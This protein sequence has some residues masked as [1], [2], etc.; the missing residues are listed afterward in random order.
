M[1]VFVT[2]AAG[3]IGKAVVKELIAHGHSVTGLTRSE[4]SASTITA[5]GGTPL[6]GDLKDLDSLKRGAAA[7]DGVIHLAFIH[8]FSDFA[9]ACATDRAAITAMAETLTGTGKPFVHASGTMMCEKDKIATE[10]SRHTPD[11]PFDER[12]K[13]ANLIYDL[14]EKGVRGSVLRFA[15]TV[16]ADGTGGLTGFLIDV[17]KGKGG[18]VVYV[19]DGQARWPACY[20]DDAA[21]LARLALEKGTAGATYHAVT[22]QGVKLK[23]VVEMIGKILKVPVQNRSVEEAVPLL[24]MFAHLMNSD[25]PASSDKTRKEL[26]WQT[27]GPTLINDFEAKLAK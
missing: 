25:N 15:P 18:P 11:P 19:G 8:D 26:G 13:S 3:F 16:H 20:R 22:E 23:D 14:A 2:G 5:L 6:P 1:H 27:T 21:V 9:G 24:G 7:A 12:S 10:D 17:F 4:N